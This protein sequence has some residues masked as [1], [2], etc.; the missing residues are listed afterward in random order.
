MAGAVGVGEADWEK[1][2]EGASGSGIL[3]KSIVV[4]IEF[5]HFGESHLR[6][7]GV[8]AIAEAL[9]HLCFHRP[10]IVVIVVV[11]VAEAAEAGCVIVLVAIKGRLGWMCLMCSALDGAEEVVWSI[12]RGCQWGE[13]RPHCHSDGY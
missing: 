3:V 13:R 11:R 12:G 9:L 6:A 10:T 8:A 5:G 1:W 2:E 7:V 4:K